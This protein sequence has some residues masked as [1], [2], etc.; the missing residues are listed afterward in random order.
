MKLL[1][2]VI[3]V[4]CATATQAFADGPAWVA[5]VSAIDPPK[6]DTIAVTIPLGSH[7]AVGVYDTTAGVYDTNA[8]E[9]QPPSGVETTVRV[10]WFEHR[11]VF[12]GMPEERQAAIPYYLPEPKDCTPTGT[13]V[14]EVKPLALGTYRVPIQCS[15]NTVYVDVTCIELPPSDIG[16]GFYTGGYPDPMRVREYH[17]DMAA[18]GMNT[19]TPYARG[20]PVEFGVDN[21]DPAALL[22]W[23]IDTAID[24][25]LVDLR[26][27][28]LCLSIGPDKL[29]QAKELAKHEWPE[30]IG[31]GIDEP[32]LDKKDALAE[33]ARQWHE[34]AKVRTGTAI[35]GPAALA[36][37]DPLDIWVIHLAT[38]SDEVVM[39]AQA[40]GKDRWLYNCELRGSNA[41]LH[42][43]YTG[44]YTWAMA[45][46]V[47]LTWTYCHDPA[48][49][50]RPDGTWNLLRVHDAATCDRDGY[51][52]PTVALEGMSDGIID[53][54]LLQ[55]LQ[56]LNTPEGNAY[57]SD[58]RAK[59]DQKFS[60]LR[61]NHG[62]TAFN[63][64]DV[65]DTAVPPIDMVAMRRDVVRL[66][67]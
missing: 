6:V 53:S 36:I 12:A 5:E 35:L 18:H 20:L 61:R 28:L 47:C 60:L 15:T 52:I 16:Y 57:L 10:M 2:A 39:A 26:F 56:R 24:E 34:V 62:W 49:R 8:V 42:R 7:V 19:F 32:G 17:R 1:V 13:W 50:I 37:G 44:V 65:R 14:V 29:R 30:L 40:R 27:P 21:Q 54:R 55:E 67:P 66:L 38:M 31:Y 63:V 25:G 23:R 58:L 33:D 22:A 11:T 3:A 59:V 4:L 64:W 43:Y 9:P 48:S 51:P 41:P 46:A 45:P